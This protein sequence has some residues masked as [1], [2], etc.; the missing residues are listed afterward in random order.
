MGTRAIVGWQWAVG[1]T[2]DMRMREM[3]L[4]TLAPTGPEVRVY[5]SPFQLQHWDIAWIDPSNAIVAWS[6]SGAPTEIYDLPVHFT[7]CP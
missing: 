3:D 1:L 7:R 2:V 6:R 4:A 5:N